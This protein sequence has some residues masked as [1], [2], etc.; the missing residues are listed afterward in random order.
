VPS[1]LGIENVLNRNVQATIAREQ[2]T[3]FH[4]FSFLLM[5]LWLTP[6]SFETMP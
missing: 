4:F 6:V 5:V 3:Y 2:A 1:N